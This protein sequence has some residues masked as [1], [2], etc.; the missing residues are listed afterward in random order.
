MV[1]MEF[2]HQLNEYFFGTLAVVFFGLLRLRNHVKSYLQKR[3]FFF[4]ISKK[5]AGTREFMMS[6]H[7]LRWKRKGFF[8]KSINFAFQC[9]WK[10]FSIE[11]VSFKSILE[12]RSLVEKVFLLSRV[13]KIYV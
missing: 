9:Y 3:F 8:L 12:Y 4:L 7:A 2:F 11:K 10:S 5:K 13:S 1:L 6:T